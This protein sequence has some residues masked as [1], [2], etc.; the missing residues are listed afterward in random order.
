MRLDNP[1]KRHDGKPTSS[2][3]AGSKSGAGTDGCW[4]VYD[5]EAMIASRPG[6]YASTRRRDGGPVERRGG[7]GE[8]L[9][10][11]ELHAGLHGQIALRECAPRAPA[12]EGYHPCPDSHPPRETTS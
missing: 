1:E 11:A 3:K 5:Y 4:R 8:R 2:E 12:S 9:V 6:H 10:V 7:E